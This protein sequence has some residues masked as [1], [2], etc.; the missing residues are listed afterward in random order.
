MLVDAVSWQAS[1]RGRGSVDFDGVGRDFLRVLN[2]S[3]SDG[4]RSLNA[5]D[6]VTAIAVAQWGGGTLTLAFKY[7]H[8]KN[9]GEKIEQATKNENVSFWLNS[10]LLIFLYT[11]KES[12]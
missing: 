12:V 8:Q 10:G 9:T 6:L 5:L 1:K 11:P 2:S 3:L 4:A 7:N